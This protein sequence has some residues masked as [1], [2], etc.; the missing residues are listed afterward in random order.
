MQS[1]NILLLGGVN[2]AHKPRDVA[3]FVADH[4]EMSD[5]TQVTLTEDTGIL[6]TAA[7]D[8]YDAFL[9][10]LNTQET[11]WPQSREAALVRAVSHGKGLFVLHAG[12]LSFRGWD[13]YTELIGGWPAPDF[14]HPPYGPFAVHIDDPAHPITAHMVDFAVR[15]ELYANVK[16]TPSARLLAHARLNEK[17]QPLLWTVAHGEARVCTLLLG[18]DRAALQYPGASTLLRRGVAWV[19]GAL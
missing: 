4:L 18:H 3:A 13:A 19:A 5:D 2:P 17:A 10:Y 6:E 1:K 15:D 11:R 8:A 9:L 7:I 14:Y 16:L 12:V